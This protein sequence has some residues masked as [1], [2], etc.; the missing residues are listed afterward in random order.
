[1]TLRRALLAVGV[2]LAAALAASREAGAQNPSYSL[3]LLGGGP[4]TL[5]SGTT[6]G[7]LEVGGLSGIAYDAAL[8]RY[9]ALADQQGSA[10]ARFFT[11]GFAV[12]E[13]GVG[14][15]SV[16]A[17]T[18]LKRPDGV[19]P[20]T[21]NDFDGE[22][23]VLTAAGT[24]WAVSET[25]PAIRQ[26]GLLTGAQIGADL[27]V[28]SPFQPAGS[29]SGLRDYKGAVRGLE[30]MTLSADGSALYTAND[31]VLKQDGPEPFTTNDNPVRLVRYDRSGLG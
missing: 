11:L 8:N 29:G 28:P 15:V 23:I 6:F 13:G 16:Q 2:A 10:P 27:A 3:S 21:G 4:A 22:G 24:F 1:M 17:V 26:F 31:L 20:F 25:E 12:N 5:P 19:T 14:P 9:Y 18:T 30:S 7:G